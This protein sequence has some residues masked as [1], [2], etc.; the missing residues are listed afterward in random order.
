MMEAPG[1][2][3]RHNLES[4]RFM[5]QRSRSTGDAVFPPRVMVPGQGM[6]DLEWGAASGLGNVYSFTLIPQSGAQTDANICLIDLDEGPRLM[7]RLIDID[8]TVIAIGLRVEA[9]ITPHEDGPFL[10]FR[11]ISGLA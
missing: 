7:S 11:P 8:S 2:A 4:G 1:Q 10:L 5:I 3:F 6:E 9:V